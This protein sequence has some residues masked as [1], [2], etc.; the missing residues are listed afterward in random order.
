MKICNKII[1]M[2][3]LPDCFLLHGDQADLK[4][5]FLTSEMIR[6]RVAFDRSMKEESYILTAAAWEDRLDSY[7]S[8]ERTH[9]DAILPEVKENDVAITFSTVDV[10]LMVEKDPLCLKLFDKAGDL[11]YSDVP[12]IAYV[13]DSNRRI[14]HTNVLTEDDFYYGFGENGGDLNKADSYIRLSGR[15][16]PDYNPVKTNPLYKHIPFYIKLNRQTKKSVGLFYHNTYECAFSLGC[17]KSNYWHRYSYYQA[18]GG[19]IDFFFLAGTSMKKILDQYT[20]LTGRPVMLPKRALGY[21]G[22]SMYYSELENNCDEAINS[23]VD[24]VQEEGFPIDGFHLSSGYSEHDNLRYVFTW[25]PNRFSDPKTYLTTMKQRSVQNVVN[26]KPGVLLTHPEYHAMESNH[27][28]IQNEEKQQTA[29]GKWWGGNGAFWDFTN[30][31]ARD[32]WKTYLTQ[33]V[34]DFGTDS[35][36]NDNCEYDGLYDKDSVCCFDGHPDTIARLKPVMANLMCKTGM[37]AILEHDS[38]A[39][40]YLVCRAGFAGIQRYAQTWCGDNYTSWEV[41]R[42]NIPIILGM[43]LSGVPNE[44]GDVGGFGGSAPDREL[45]VRW[46]QNG[47]FQPRFSVHSVNNDNT[48]TELWMY[49]DVKDIIRDAVL[50]RYHFTPYLYSAMY[51]AHKTGEPIM[52]P[53]VYEFQEDTACYNENFEFMFGRDLLVANVLEPGAVTKDIYLP[54][55]CTW[56]DY[57]T[58]QSY[59]GGQTI[60]I[61]VQL[62]S[63]PMYLRE[64]AVIPMA[65]NP[66]LSMERDHATNLRILIVPQDDRDYVLYDD[67]GR[68]NEYLSGYYR[69]TAIHISTANQKINISMS[70]TGKYTNWTKH[71]ELELVSPKRCPVQIG[72]NDTLI[73]RYTNYGHYRKAEIGWYYDMTKNSV[74]IRCN[75]DLNQSQIQISYELFDMIKL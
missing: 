22:S 14:R 5:Y 65:L 74:L 26:V 57:Y 12:E 72:I 55:G 50:L 42:Y 13:L 10:T 17:E 4:I 15:D 41:L 44:G 28:F 37:E 24:T 30:P 49:E 32:L 43:G 71:L 68:S 33:K 9:I 40:P 51:H 45:F 60:T 53:L 34:I 25:N 11:L 20:F 54:A 31:E 69:M 2:E 29:I 56:Y 66:I 35:I 23:F 48:V 6:V 64:G 16:A 7:L 59:E 38:N 3:Q 70:S 52:R 47:I 62:D 46:I 21:Q 1:T 36:W 75:P 58:H 61:P 8:D 19:D 18:D 73:K 63:I 39:R 27:A 67:D